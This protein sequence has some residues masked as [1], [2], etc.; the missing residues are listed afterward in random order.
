M[1]GAV[2]VGGCYYYKKQ[3]HSHTAA[4]GGWRIVF[5]NFSLD[6]VGSINS[7]NNWN[8]VLFYSKYFI[9]I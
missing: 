7:G 4:A 9:Y 2:V 8:S 6:R 3:S 5:F 1:S